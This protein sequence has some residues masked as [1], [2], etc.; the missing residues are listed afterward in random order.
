MNNWYENFKSNKNFQKEN[1]KYPVKVSA[2]KTFQEKVIF[3]MWA[4]WDIQLYLLET[5][6]F[7]TC[8]NFIDNCY[9]DNVDVEHACSSLVEWFWSI[10]LPRDF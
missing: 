9:N 3:Y 1:P 7:N 10:G 8:L 5:S 2:R 4:E 6:A